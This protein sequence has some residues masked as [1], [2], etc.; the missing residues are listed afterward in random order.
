MILAALNPTASYSYQLEDRSMSAL[1]GDLREHIEQ[2]RLSLVEH[3]VDELCRCLSSALISAHEDGTPVN[4]E[5][6]TRAIDV[7]RALLPY[8]APLP[9]IIVESDGTV[10]LDW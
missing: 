6:W 1:G 5:A 4:P 7:L 8:D 9:T 2:A 3:R 10:G